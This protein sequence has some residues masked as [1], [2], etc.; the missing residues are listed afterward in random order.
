LSSRVLTVSDQEEVELACDSIEPF[1]TLLVTEHAGDTDRQRLLDELK[2][3]KDIRDGT[4]FCKA[5]HVYELIWNKRVHSRT[6]HQTLRNIPGIKYHNITTSRVMKGLV[7]DNKYGEEL[8]KKM[9]DYTI[10]IQDPLVSEDQI[11]CWLAS[12]ARKLYRTINPSDYSPLCHDPIV[13][14]IE[15]KTPDGS[16]EKALVQLSIWVMAHFNRLRA[17]ATDPV[18]ITLPLL[19]VSGEH[20]QLMF[21]RDIESSIV[22]CHQLPAI[23]ILML[24]SQEIFDCVTIGNTESILGCYKI[25]TALRHLYN[26]AATIF[27]PW[28]VNNVLTPE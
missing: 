27:Q 6:L 19:F 16:R 8:R 13:I 9:V 4:S 17:L 2:A 11:T 10:T 21:I 20:W 12:S 28:F 24:I 22:S 18:S 15:T 7:P 1:D 26:W 5:K 25:L 14:S 3:I 23:L